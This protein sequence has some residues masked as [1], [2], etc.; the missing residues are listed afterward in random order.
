MAGVVVMGE[1]GVVLLL[2]I[3]LLARPK[4]SMPTPQ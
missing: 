4:V 3:P 2:Q 1:D